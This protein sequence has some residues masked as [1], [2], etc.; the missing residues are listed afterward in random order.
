MNSDQN[1]QQPI[2]DRSIE[3]LLRD[4]IFNYRSTLILI[5]LGLAS[6]LLG[7]IL[8]IGGGI[9]IVP[10]LV[11]FFG[12]NQHKAHGT[13]LLVA[14]FLS[15]A[16]VITYATHG[17]VDLL[18][19]L[20][21]AIGGVI[22]ALIGAKIVG[23]IKSRT[24]KKAFCVFLAII[25]VLM[26]LNGVFKHNFI[27]LSWGLKEDIASQGITVFLTGVLT[28]CFKCIAWNRR[29]HDN[30]TRACYFASC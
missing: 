12:L 29:R 9:I 24:L 25:A 26:I 28:G 22:G 7:G 17:K 27:H 16:G 23:V 8:G 19:A 3:A 11:F 30:D 15:I 2:K 20:E 10:G 6:G 1:I 21:M 4:F 13:S 18:M 14:L 5:A